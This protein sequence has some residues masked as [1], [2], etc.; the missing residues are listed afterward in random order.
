[1]GEEPE[2]LTLEDIYEHLHAEEQELPTIGEGLLMKATH[3]SFI[4]MTFRV[5]NDLY[6]QVQN[7]RKSIIKELNISEL[8]LLLSKGPALL[9][10]S[11]ALDIIDEQYVRVDSVKR[12]IKSEK[13]LLK[14]IKSALKVLQKVNLEVYNPDIIFLLITINEK[15]GALIDDLKEF[16]KKAKLATSGITYYGTNENQE[17]LERCDKLIENSVMK[18]GLKK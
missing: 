13:V 4:D 14:S 16:N 7:G 8:L 6:K 1:M 10:N 12:E 5:T 15:N 17:S 9:F 2:K 11:R 3:D 18:L